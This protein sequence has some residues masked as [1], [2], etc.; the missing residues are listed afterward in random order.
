MIRKLAVILLFLVVPLHNL[1]AAPVWASKPIQCAS[2]EEVMDLVEKMN[3]EPFI[4]FEGSSSRPGQGQFI[5]KF[6]ITL[7]S[8]SGG[9][10][11]IEIP[12]EDQACILGAGKGEIKINK[13]GITT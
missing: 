5:S 1:N 9:W 4:Y 3:E 11:L 10:T 8:K 13:M 7:N 6:L 2:T 12:H